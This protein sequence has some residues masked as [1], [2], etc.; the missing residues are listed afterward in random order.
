MTSFCLLG[1]LLAATLQQVNKHCHIDNT[2]DRAYR[3]YPVV[4]IQEAACGRSD[5]AKQRLDRRAQ[6]QHCACVQ[7]QSRLSK[8]LVYNPCIFKILFQMFTLV[9]GHSR[10]MGRGEPCRFQIIFCWFGTLMFDTETSEVIL[11]SLL[12]STAAPCNLC[13]TLFCKN[14]GSYILELLDF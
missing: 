12:L 13:L 11:L 5:C 10:S 4:H 9:S 7:E 8:Q 3:G 2:L 1:R 14:V 6:S